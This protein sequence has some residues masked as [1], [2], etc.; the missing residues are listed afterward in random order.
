MTQV[1]DDLPATE[2]QLRQMKSDPDYLRIIKYMEDIV[3]LEAP[4]Y[5]FING[6]W[7]GIEDKTIA[8]RLA[9]LKAMLDAYVAHTY[10]LLKQDKP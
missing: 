9:G 7:T 8:E 3:S 2:W 6:K 4:K 1:L 5:A 10:P